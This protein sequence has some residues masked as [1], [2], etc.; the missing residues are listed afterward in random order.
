MY[1]KSGGRSGF[2]PHKSGRKEDFMFKSENVTIINLTPHTI[3]VLGTDNQPVMAIEPSGQLARLSTSRECIGSVN[4]IPVNATVMGDLT[5]LPDPQPGIVYLVSLAAA[6]AVP[7]RDD[8]FVTDDAVR[9]ETGR[10]VGCRAF[11]RV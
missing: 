7:D 6:K 11:A 8:V 10:I 3:N 9:D 5:G 1:T 2:D 4:G